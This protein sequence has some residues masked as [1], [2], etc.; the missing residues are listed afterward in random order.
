MES[1][2][3]LEGILAIWIQ[4]VENVGYFISTILSRKSETQTKI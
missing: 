2:T 3:F 4:K 1:G